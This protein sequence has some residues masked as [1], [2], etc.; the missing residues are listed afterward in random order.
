MARVGDR[1]SP[2]EIVANAAR[3]QQSIQ[4]CIKSGLRFLEDAEWLTHRES[5]GVALAMLAQEEFAK[6]FV[7]ALVRDGILPWTEEVQRSLRVHECKHLVTIIMEWL[8]AVNELRS[9]QSLDELLRRDESLHLPPDVAIAMNIYRHEMIERIGGRNPEHYAEWGGTARKVAKGKR[10]RK[11]QAALYVD[12]RDDGGV[13]SEPTMSVQEFEAEFAHARKLMEFAGD[14]DRK[15]VFALREYE[16]FGDIF[17]SMFA[18]SLTVPKELPFVT[19]EYPSGIPG[20][21][22]AKRTITVADVVTELAR[23]AGLEENSTVG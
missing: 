16:L 3:L 15:C 2:G 12:I 10:D 5:T 19:E 18:E 7:L 4:A 8:L 17:R 22:L 20:I 13:A 11:K 6:A 14:V 9:S 23:P 1:F 21:V